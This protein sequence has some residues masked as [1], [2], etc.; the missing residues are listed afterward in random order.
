[1]NVVAVVSNHADLA[2]VAQAEGVPF[3]HYPIAAA[4]K[5]EQEAQAL[6]CFRD[7]RA[8]AGAEFVVPARYMQVPC[9]PRA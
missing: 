8:G 2:A 3:H 4:T 9:T 5:P 6:R 1:M 7:A